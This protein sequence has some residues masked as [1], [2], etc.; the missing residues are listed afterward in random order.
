MDG[1][2]KRKSFVVKVVSE[3]EKNI[4]AESLQDSISVPN[5]LTSHSNE[6]NHEDLNEEKKENNVTV[7]LDDANSHP[8]ANDAQISSNEAKITSFEQLG[9]CEPLLE[10]CKELNWITPSDIQALALPHAMKGKDIIALA[11]TG[12]GKT[13]AFALPIIEALVQNPSPYFALILSPTRELAIQIAETFEKLGKSIG[14]R[15]VTLVGGIDNVSQAIALGKRPHVLVATPGRIIDHLEN[16]KGFNLR[17]LKFLVFD[18]ADR[19]LNMDYQDEIDKLLKIVPSQRNT[20]LFSATMTT[21]VQKLQRASLKNPVKVE[22]NVNGKYTTV[23]TL[24]QQYSFH[25]AKFKDTYLAFI[26]NEFAG[27]ST[28]V[29]CSTCDATQ[30]LAIMLRS[31]GF[32]AI[33]LNGKMQQAKRIASLAHFKSGEKTILLATDVASRG[34]DIPCVDLVINY[35]MP[36]N[37]KEYIH[38]VGRTARAGRTGRAICFVTQYDVE[39]F[40][41]VEDMLG[42]KLP[43]YPSEEETVLLLHQRVT[44]AQ[45]IAALEMKDAMQE[46]KEKKGARRDSRGEK[47]VGAQSKFKKGKK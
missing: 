27:H 9:L 23:K 5:E 40:Q 24:V 31:L 11:E 32:G 21:K 36:T 47:S 39:L 33:P 7:C 6:E 28:I 3:M 29:F 15:C 38:R 46:E 37:G 45:R 34:L 12:S 17:N 13:G 25:P 42:F 30:R 22:A 4:D 26:L 14:L 20:Y 2:K 10:A 18:E 35:D 1:V 44:E 43:A 16:T 41:R 19:L 8:S